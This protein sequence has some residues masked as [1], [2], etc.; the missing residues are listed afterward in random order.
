MSEK[1]SSYKIGL[2]VLVGTAILLLSL[3]LFGIRTAFEP[4][5][6]L[7]TYVTGDVGGLSQGS[8]VLLRGVA[9]GKVT[10]IGFSWNLYHSDSPRCVVVRFAIKESVSPVT[11]GTDLGPSVDGLVAKGLRAIIKGQGITGTSVVSLEYEDAARYPPLKVSWTPKYYYIPSAPSQFG[12]ILDAVDRTLS[13]LEKFDVDRLVNSLDRT[14]TTADA[15]LK[16]LGQLD[17][18]GIS[19]GATKVVADAAVAIREV[20]G[21]AQEARKSL[22]EMKL[23]AVGQDAS[24]LLNNVDERLA[25]L[26]DKLSGIDVRALNE[27]LAGTQEAAR[28]LNDALEE[29]KKYPSGF[30]FGGAPPPAA[31]LE[32]EKH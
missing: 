27:T 22:Q 8:A 14:L 13:H 3:F 7:E 4:T 2:F 5:H 18:R 23:G 24:R 16:N 17:V 20:S 9:V 25:A 11:V 6:K 15:A 29:L 32:K 28:N 30:L 10:Q 1:A 21:L 26:I 19:G 12:Q 31:G